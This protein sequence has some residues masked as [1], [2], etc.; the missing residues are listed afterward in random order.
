[1]GPYG[2][3]RRSPL[4]ALQSARTVT[5]C[6]GPIRMWKACSRRACG[7]AHNGSHKGRLRI[8]LDA[9]LYGSP[10]TDRT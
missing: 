8:V 4:N 9:R 3:P 10:D 7:T 6:A 1:M 2:T 5:A